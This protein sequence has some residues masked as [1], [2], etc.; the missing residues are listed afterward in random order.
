LYNFNPEEKNFSDT[1]N[2]QIKHFA[3]QAREAV[4]SNQKTKTAKLIKVIKPKI[5]IKNLFTDLSNYEIIKKTQIC[6]KDKD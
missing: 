2:T 5:I 6:I 4:K 1:E 3:I